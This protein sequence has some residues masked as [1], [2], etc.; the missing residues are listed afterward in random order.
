MY[1]NLLNS[2]GVVIDGTTTTQRP[3]IQQENFG[4]ILSDPSNLDIPRVHN[5]GEVI[6]G[7]I[8]M[9]NNLKIIDG[10]YYGQFTDILK[11]NGGVHEPQEE[12]VFGEVMK[13]IPKGGVMIELGA[14]WGFYSLWFYSLVEGATTYLV[15]PIKE[16][17]EFGMSNFK[18]NNF[19]GD[20]THA[21]I[22]P[23]VDNWCAYDPG[24]VPTITID[25]FVRQKK[26]NFIDILHADI[27]AAEYSMLI[28]AKETL[29]EGKIK[30]LFISTHND[31]LHHRCSAFLEAMD[32]EIIAS[33]DSNQT[34]SSDGVL[35]ARLKDMEGVG[36][37]ELSD[38]SQTPLLP[39]QQVRRL[40]ARSGCIL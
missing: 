16:N 17:L 22:G 8:I 35:V 24:D 9:H 30:Y 34:F 23:Y 31:I 12:K 33:A 20:F 26:I 7:K 21:A 39:P 5:A 15:E 4:K 37:I 27:Q 38:C 32:Y 36:P 40:F 10:S 13:T 25:T 19:V 29:R 3:R 6:D 1:I 14:F 18:A 28:G 11:V 2:V